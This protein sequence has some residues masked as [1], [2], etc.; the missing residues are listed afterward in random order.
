MKLRV[1]PLYRNRAEAPAA[2]SEVE[3]VTS[4]KVLARVQA[5]C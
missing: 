3:A 2:I 5:T 1:G 4:G